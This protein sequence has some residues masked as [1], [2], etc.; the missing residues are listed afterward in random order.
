MLTHNGHTLQINTY[1]IFYTQTNP[2]H[3]MSRE[4]DFTLQIKIN[5]FTRTMSVNY[6]SWTQFY[7]WKNER[8]CAA[9]NRKQFCPKLNII[10]FYSLS[11]SLYPTH[12]TT[13][14]LMTES[15]TS[16]LNIHIN[17]RRFFQLDPNYNFYYRT[18]TQNPSLLPCIS[19]YI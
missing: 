7:S 8:N 17:I 18:S 13:C 4:A 19:T 16:P 1:Y 3:R 5:G 6:F 12:Y 15:S 11:V 10:N 14:N 9:E 2:K